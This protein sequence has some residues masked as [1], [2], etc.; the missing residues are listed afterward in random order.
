MSRRFTVET[1]RN[2]YNG[3]QRSRPRRFERLIGNSPA[4]EEVLEGVERVA[5]TSSTV[6][7]DSR[8]QPEV[9]TS[10]CQAELRCDP[11]G[12]AGKRAFWPRKGRI[13]GGH[14]AEAWPFRGGR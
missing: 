9:W 13:Y 4:L 12:S 11:T 2:P 8:Y 6:L 7:I 3:D 14:S 1:I 5:P 10:V